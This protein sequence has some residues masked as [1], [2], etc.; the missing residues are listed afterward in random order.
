MTRRLIA[1]IGTW[2]I[3]VAV[4]V[5][6]PEFVVAQASATSAAAVKTTRAAKTYVA[7]RT[8]DGQPDLQGY[9]SNTSYT[10][11]ERPNGVNKEFYS[12]DEAEE[13]IKRAAATESEQTEP[14]T[15]P[16]VHYD[17]TQ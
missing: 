6:T 8:P 16:D 9:W 5:L 14:G 17:F 12:K 1:S 15:I 13:I 10:P 3:L 7:P 11:L 2:G 4:V